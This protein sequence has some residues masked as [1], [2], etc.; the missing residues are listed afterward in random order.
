[1]GAHD[2]RVLRRPAPVNYGP[3]AAMT[4]ARRSR[5]ASAEGLA[6]IADADPT[7]EVVVA[8]ARNW[9]REVRALGETLDAL[10]R[11]SRPSL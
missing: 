9:T 10:G 4:L 5:S 1:M 7:F 2:I 8:D 3:S 6:V 11:P